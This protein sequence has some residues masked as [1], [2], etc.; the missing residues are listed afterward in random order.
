MLSCAYATARF[1]LAAVSPPFLWFWCGLHNKVVYW[2]D[3][4]GKQTATLLFPAAPLHLGIC[5]NCDVQLVNI[6][7]D[8]TDAEKSM[9]LI[10]YETLAS[11]MYQ[12]CAQRIVD[13]ATAMKTC[14]SVVIS[15]C[16]LPGNEWLHEKDERIAPFPCAH[17]PSNAFFF[18][19]APIWF[20]H[21]HTLCS[22]CLLF[23]TTCLN[24]R[25]RVFNAFKRVYACLCWLFTSL[26]ETTFTM[27][28]LLWSVYSEPASL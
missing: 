8:K 6:E 12:M 9:P 10:R 14:R 3:N 25:T 21:C 19:F 18:S 22:W 28:S 5:Y 2:P 16:A 1:L 4:P 13:L 24:V 11:N 27:W 26:W 7:D 23:T 20:D 15:R 17:F